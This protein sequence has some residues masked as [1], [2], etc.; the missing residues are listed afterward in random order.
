VVPKAT[1]EFTGSGMWPR[2]SNESCIEIAALSPAL[3]NK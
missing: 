2:E 1:L 3:T